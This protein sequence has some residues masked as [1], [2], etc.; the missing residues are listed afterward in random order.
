MRFSW[1]DEV[2]VRGLGVEGHLGVSNR[3]C[4]KAFRRSGRKETISGIC[5]PVKPPEPEETT[6]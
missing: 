4:V 6:Q 1:E 2:A 5:E 3:T